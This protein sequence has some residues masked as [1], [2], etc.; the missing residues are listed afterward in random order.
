MQP[1]GLLRKRTLHRVGDHHDHAR[2]REVVPE[3]QRH[4]DRRR[5]P[6]VAWDAQPTAGYARV[7][8]RELPR[9][10]AAALALAARAQPHDVAQVAVASRRLGR[11]PPRG[12]AAAAAALTAGTAAAVAH[13]LLV[14][15][16]DDVTD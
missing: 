12:R 11:H 9:D 14:L 5:R 3:H 16:D 13:D 2:V 8:L 4:A 6:T 10:G 15:T 1:G 7:P